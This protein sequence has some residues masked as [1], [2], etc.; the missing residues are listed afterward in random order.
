MP[1]ANHIEFFRRKIEMG[2]KQI[3]FSLQPSC[4]HFADIPSGESQQQF[5]L[6]S[7]LYCLAAGRSAVNIGFQL[8]HVQLGHLAEGSIGCL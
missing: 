2:A 3:L 8:L 6:L 1:L 5:I 7:L 4:C